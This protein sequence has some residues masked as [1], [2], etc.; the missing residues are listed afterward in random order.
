MILFSFSFFV[1]QYEKYFGSN[2]PKKGGSFYLQSKIYRAKESLDFE[3]KRA[4]K[5]NNNSSNTTNS[6]NSNSSS[7]SNSNNSSKP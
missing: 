4:E 1:Q 7:S 6:N 5:N 3:L 2:D